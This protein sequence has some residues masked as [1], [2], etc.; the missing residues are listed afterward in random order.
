MVQM[1]ILFKF[2]LSF[3]VLKEVQN[4]MSDNFTPLCGQLYPFRSKGKFYFCK[5]N[6]LH[7]N[8]ND[9]EYF[10]GSYMPVC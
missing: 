5:K 8:G 9:T 10:I 4:C 1:L 3:F 6:E 2:I 7:N